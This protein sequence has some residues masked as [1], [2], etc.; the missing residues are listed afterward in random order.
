MFVLKEHLEMWS[1]WESKARDI[2]QISNINTAQYLNMSICLNFTSLPTSAITLSQNFLASFCGFLHFL[3]LF[4][5]HCVFLHCVCLF[6]VA[7]KNSSQF[8]CRVARPIPCITAISV[9]KQWYCTG[10]IHFHKR[11]L[12]NSTSRDPL[13]QQDLHSLR[14]F[15]LLFLL[16]SSIFFILLSA[17]TTG[18]GLKLWKEYDLQLSYVLDYRQSIF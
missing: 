6:I 3:F 10:T 4:L 15:S 11:S 12:W 5:N 14:I 17:H 8:M 16:N 18:L 1:V 13:T 7:Y 2:N 9:K